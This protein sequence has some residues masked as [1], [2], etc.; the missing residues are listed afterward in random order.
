[1]ALESGGLTTPAPKFDGTAGVRALFPIGAILQGKYRLDRLLGVGAMASVAGRKSKRSCAIQARAARGPHNA[2]TRPPC[3]TRSRHA[4]TPTNLASFL[5]RP[6]RAGER[7]SRGLRLHGRRISSTLRVPSPVDRLGDLP[8]TELRGF[9]D[10]EACLRTNGYGH[11]CW[12]NDAGAE[13]CRVC[14]SSTDCDGA[15]LTQAEFIA[16]AREPGRASCHVGLLQACLL[17]QALRGPGDSRKTQ[18]CRSS[19]LACAGE[20][21]GDLT[22]QAVAALTE[23]DQV[24]VEECMK[25]VGMASQLDPDASTIG[26]WQTQLSMWEGGLPPGDEPDVEGGR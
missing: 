7:R 25:E 6:A 18:A 17:Q 8:L 14:I 3:P 21:S 2:R 1:M 22:T 15:P 13:R 5:L 16:H 9:C 20:L 10:W 24:T 4:G 12:I 26:Y 11:T 19:D 23:T